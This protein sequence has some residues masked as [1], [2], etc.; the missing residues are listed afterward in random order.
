MTRSNW[1][2][3]LDAHPVLSK[4]QIRLI[5]VHTHGG[6]DFYRLMNA[7]FQRCKE[8]KKRLLALFKRNAT[9]TERLGRTIQ[10]ILF[11]AK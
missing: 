4:D 8:R 3:F 7:Y 10:G 5:R 1:N 11:G 6:V 9:P 2:A